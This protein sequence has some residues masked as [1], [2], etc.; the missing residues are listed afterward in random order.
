MGLSLRLGLGLSSPSMGGGARSVF[1]KVPDLPTS[2]P[3]MGFTVTGVVILPGDRL[4]LADG[5]GKFNVNTPGSFVPALVEVARAGETALNQTPVAVYYLSAM[6]LGLEESAG[7]PVVTGNYSIQGLGYRTD[8]GTIVVTVPAVSGTV[9][10]ILQI[11]PNTGARV[12]AVRVATVKINHFEPDNAA[13]NYVAVNEGAATIRRRSY[14][15]G[16]S[17]GTDIVF[18]NQNALDHADYA[19]VNHLH[20]SADHNSGVA[21]IYTVSTPADMASAT[22]LAT[23]LLPD[24]KSI[25]GHRSRG[26]V[27]LLVANDRYYHVPEDALPNCLVSIKPNPLFP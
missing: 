14:A 7:V 10:W 18:S 5:V 4:F 22:V 13:G 2:A 15:S 21:R 8:L 6:M 11:N 26:A 16:A 23:T 12:S 1:M 24:I 19:G 3:G 20:I 9:T 25:E 17:V 27:E